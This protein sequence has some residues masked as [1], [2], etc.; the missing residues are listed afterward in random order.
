MNNQATFEDLK[1]QEEHGRIKA[2]TAELD[3]L[4]K[5]VAYCIGRKRFG[6][7]IDKAGSYVNE[8]LNSNNEEGQKPFQPYMIAALIV[9][10]P[11]KFMEIV[12][13]PICDL[14][15]YDRPEK[16]RKRSAEEELKE[17]RKTIK[18]K[19]LDSVFPEHF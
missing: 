17:L 7:L 11:S 8:L 4:Y 16:K 12:V 2:I 9:G 14:C 1:I 19:G 6:E 3:R 10:C 15:G 13:F 18:A 5:N